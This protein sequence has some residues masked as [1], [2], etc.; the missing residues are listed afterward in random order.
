MNETEPTTTYDWMAGESPVTV[1][2]MGVVRGGVNGMDHA[3]GPSGTY[4]ISSDTNNHN[5]S[6]DRFVL[7]LDH[8]S[9]VLVKLCSRV[10]CTHDTADCNAYLY[11]GSDLSYYCG[12][13]Y[14]ITGEGPDTKESKLVRIEPDGANHV[15]M[16]D[17]REFAEECGGDYVYCDMITSG[18]C[19]FTTYRWAENTDGGVTGERLECYKYKL[20]GSMDK[21]EVLEDLGGIAYQ[22]GNVLMSIS[23]ETSTKS[24]WSVD[25]EMNSKT[26]LTEHPGIPGWFGEEEAYY[27]KDGAIIR[28]CYVTDR[29]EVVVDTG[30][31]GKYYLF[32]FPDCLV[33]ASRDDAETADDNLYFY[34]WDF[35]LVD[36]VTIDYPHTMRTQFLLAAETPEQFILTDQ[37]LVGE[38]LYYI[39]KS[40]LGTGNVEIHTFELS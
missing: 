11:M 5:S 22:C 31:D 12:F 7:Y 33:L 14:G 25:L 8:G 4:F 29:E 23:N 10:D 15:T 40:E 35:E 1:N 21:P 16:F 9:N 27:F 26:Y 34:N 2:R 3:V 28:L 37:P 36:T 17:L 38:P 20:D 24:C 19:L 13:L 39:N 32:V 6:E 18:Y 30:L